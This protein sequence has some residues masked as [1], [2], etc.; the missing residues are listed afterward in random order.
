MI[1]GEEIRRARQRAGWSQGE[2]AKRVGT[3]Q[4][5]VGNWER[6]D[7]SPSQREASVRQALEGFLDDDRPESVSLSSVSDVELL[8]EVARRLGRAHSRQKEVAHHDR[9]A[10]IT[11]AEDASA[12]PDELAKRREPTEEEFLRMAADKAPENDPREA[13]EREWSLRSEES[14]E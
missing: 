2:L 1:T 10:P 12:N 5:T 9:E 3:S 8:G 4:R 14:Q 6:G 11:Q 7:T 13:R